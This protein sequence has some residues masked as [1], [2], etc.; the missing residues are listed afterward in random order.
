[1]TKDI[2][3]ARDRLGSLVRNNES[4]FGG[5]DPAVR[6]DYFRLLWCFERI[7]SGWQVMGDDGR[8]FLSHLIDWHVDEWSFALPEARRRLGM[9]N[10]DDSRKGIDKLVDAMKKDPISWKL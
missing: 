7:W 5:S 4:A 1:M 10:D 2:A 6:H 9:I 8:K 3:D